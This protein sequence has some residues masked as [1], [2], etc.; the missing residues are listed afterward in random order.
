MTSAFE[1]GLAT[2]HQSPEALSAR[3][4]ALRKQ[5]VESDI[6]GARQAALGMAERYEQAAADRVAS[7]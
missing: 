3:A 1:E 7:R 4:R 2:T 6:D 5:A